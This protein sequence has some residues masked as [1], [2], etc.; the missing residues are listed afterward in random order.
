MFVLRELLQKLVSIPGPC[1]FEHEVARYLFDRLKGSADDAWVDGLGNVLIKRVGAHPGPTLMLS[2][3]ADEVGF[4]VKKIE[5]NGLLRFEKVG[6]HDDRVLLSEHVTV[7]TQE[8]KRYEGVIGCISCHMLRFDDP[9]LVRKHSDMYIDV[10]ARDAEGVRRMGIQVADPITWA[11]PYREF[12]EG[13]A[14]GHA[15]DDRAGCAV[16]AKCLEE[17]DFSKVHGTVYGVFSTQEEL[18]LRGARVASQQI[19]AD[20]A[21]AI[22]TTA[23]S[24]TFEG[25]MDHTLAL[26]AGVGIK[27]MDHSL[28]ASVAVRRQLTEL[29]VQ[30]GIPHQIE[31]FCGIGTD[32]GEMHKEKAGV[33][34]C[35]LSI[36][37]RY[38]HCPYEVI[39][40]GDL[41]ATHDLLTRFIL[42]MRSREEFS[43]LR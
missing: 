29:A 5:P 2:A 43:F 19:T 10:G 18:G 7:T 26:G 12:G 16:L 39:D 37:S 32:A 36:P 25:M 4:I 38:A 35:T 22:D 31:V 41:Q 14:M 1:G 15:F 17:I 11:T 40:L 24:D 27:A 9:H 6:G 23:V 20:V 30:H 42:S 13:R 33:P 21:I 8:G 3:H 34:T 28:M